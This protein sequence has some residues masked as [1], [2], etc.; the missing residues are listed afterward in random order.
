MSNRF[1]DDYNDIPLKDCHDA[2]GY[3]QYSLMWCDSEQE[4]LLRRDYELLEA[5]FID[6]FLLSKGTKLFDADTMLDDEEL[7]SDLNTE[8]V[9]YLHDLDILK[10]H[11]ISA[12]DVFIHEM[13][14]CP[15]FNE[16][17]M[18]TLVSEK[19]AA[20]WRIKRVVRQLAKETGKHNKPDSK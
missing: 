4:L 15:D 2:I 1:K 17:D 19:R 8:E 12:R 9:E 5:V 3:L 18:L 6:I 16:Y 20:A 7:L 10:C 13:P 14:P 11:Y